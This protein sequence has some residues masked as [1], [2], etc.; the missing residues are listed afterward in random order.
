M[1]F[2]FL[3]NGTIFSFFEDDSIIEPSSFSPR[4]LGSSSSL[5]VPLNITSRLLITSTDVIH[6]FAV[7]SMALKVDAIPGRINQIFMTPLRC[8]VFYGQC[9][10]ICGSNHS[11]MPISVKVVDHLLFG[12]HMSSILINDVL[13]VNK[14]SL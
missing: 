8:G 14:L 5:W 11:F 1:N 6:S 13:E 12:T 9:S 4:L 10:E 3:F 7:P 2:Y